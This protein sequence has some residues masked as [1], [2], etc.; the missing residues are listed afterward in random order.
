MTPWEEGQTRGQDGLVSSCKV[1]D[2]LKIIS[3]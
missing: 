2:N 1:A 3:V